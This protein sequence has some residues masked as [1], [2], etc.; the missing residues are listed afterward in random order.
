MTEQ[1]AVIMAHPDDVEIWAGGTLINHRNRGDEILITY[2]FCKNNKRQMEA[3]SAARTLGASLVIIGSSNTN[4][5][6]CIIGD[7]APTII[8]TH[9]EEDTHPD[10][11]ATFTAVTR[12]LPELVIQRELQPNLFCCDCYNSIGRRGD[13]FAPTTMVDVTEVWMEKMELIHLHKSQP[14]TYWQDMI[15]AQAKLHGMRAGVS[16]AESF[17][18]VPVLGI[19]KNSAKHLRGRM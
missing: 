7:F 9:W 4:E 17:I 10:H 5:L 3:R 14:I 18:Q 13:L 19:M 1:I 2:L 8:I 15:T 11:A 16:Y 12:M 6:A